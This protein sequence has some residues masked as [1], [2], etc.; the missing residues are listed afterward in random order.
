MSVPQGLSANIKAS[1]LMPPDATGLRGGHRFE[2]GYSA[3]L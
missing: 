2:S 1:K 3:I